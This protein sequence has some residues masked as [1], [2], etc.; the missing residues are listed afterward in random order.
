MLSCLGLSTLLTDSLPIGRQ[1]FLST[2]INMI[3]QTP[4]P[5]YLSSPFIP[6][7]FATVRVNMIG[8]TP[9]P[10]YLSSPFIPGG[11]ATVRDISSQ[12][13]IKLNDLQVHLNIY[14]SAFRVGS[15]C[16]WRSLSEAQGLE[17]WYCTSPLAGTSTNM[18]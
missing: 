7:G 14:D 11:F 12:H 5:L 2:Y 17:G 9:K 15:H 3:G 4:K 18:A 1:A 13:L 8:Q 10:L 16:V 6:G